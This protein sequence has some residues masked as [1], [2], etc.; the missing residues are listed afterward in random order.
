MYVMIEKGLNATAPW[1]GMVD[2]VHHP[3]KAFRFPPENGS[4]AS[5][6]R[7]WMKE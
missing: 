7:L 1:W 2:S 3:R 6:L 4:T 5:R